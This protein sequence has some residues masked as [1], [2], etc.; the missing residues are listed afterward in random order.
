MEKKAGEEEEDGEKWVF[1]AWR[2]DKK[3]EGR[4]SKNLSLTNLS[5][6]WI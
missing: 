1:G 2:K 5:S 3:N 4:R 6:T